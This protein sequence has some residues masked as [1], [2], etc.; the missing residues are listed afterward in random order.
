M[1]G[2]RNQDIDQP[3]KRDRGSTMFNPGMMTSA[4]RTTLAE[5]AS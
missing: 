5:A 1:R 3:G 2:R 4:Y